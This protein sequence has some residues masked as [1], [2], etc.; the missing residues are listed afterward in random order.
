MAGFQGGDEVDGFALKGCF[1]EEGEG[2]WRVG[3]VREQCGRVCEGFECCF[4]GRY[5]AVD[6]V[7][8]D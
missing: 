7:V 5:D 6:F 4:L 1:A 8:G 2:L 3:E